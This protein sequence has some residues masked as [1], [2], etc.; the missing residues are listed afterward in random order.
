MQPTIP[1][2]G[3][4][5]AAPAAAT[6]SLSV[7]GHALRVA[8]GQ[9]LAARVLAV[10]GGVVELAIAGGR[11]SARTAL[12]LQP[13]Q[14]LRLVVSATDSERVTLR[15]A[16]TGG[17]G[18]AADTA[19]RSPAFG[20]LRA[21][22][23][24]APAAGAVLA[25]L[26]E[27]GAPP[28]TADAAAR[29]GARAADAGVAGRTMAT[30]FVRLD[31][32]GLP[33][34]PAAVAGL[35]ALAHGPAVGRALATVIDAARAAAPTIG[36]TAAPPPASRPSAGRAANPQAPPPAVTSPA[37]SAP[38]A[39]S[40][41]PAGSV[42]AP[43]GGPAPAHPSPAPGAAPP[44]GGTAPIAAALGGLVDRIARDAVSG[45]VA[46]LRAAIA[47]LGAGLEARLARGDV[48]RDAPVR[49]LLSALASHPATEPALA[50]AAAGLADA[51]AAQPLAVTAGGPTPAG[52]PAPGGAYLQLPLPGGGTVEVRVDPDAAGDEDGGGAHAARRVAFLLDL[53][54]L[55]SVMVMA[56]ATGDADPVDARV[57]AAD[58]G[59]RSF[60][61]HDISEL[62][63][64]LGTDGRPARVRVEALARA[65]PE[66]LIAPPPATGLDRRA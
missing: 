36:G 10:A 21:A 48:P 32:A 38:A 17:T 39:P 58:E 40:A 34:T 47:D 16:L 12:P 57:R 1:A 65:T 53:S 61:A 28:P 11:M 51:V 15:P 8:V 60:L 54:A 27:A 7:P 6:G 3:A 14:A 66:R 24:T 2:A 26:A 9:E 62:A 31:A 22:G 42:P 52:P 20:A 25:A 4:P 43:G 5:G 18:P 63:A 30:A 56:T 44:A 33:T 55:G 64:A 13:G 29:L 37:P 46:A 23:L 19:G 49:A 35:A 41:T 59:V 45:D 50:R